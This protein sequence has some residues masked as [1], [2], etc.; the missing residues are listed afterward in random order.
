[1]AVSRASGIDHFAHDALLLAALTSGD[2]LEA[3]DRARA[4]AQVRDCAACAALL[5]DLVAIRAATVELPAP[6]RRRDFRLTEADAARLRPAGWRRVLVAFGSPRARLA[7]PASLGLAT[8]GIAGLLLATVPTALVAERSG[9][10][11]TGAEANGAAVAAAPAATAAPAPTPPPVPAPTPAGA[12]TAAPFGG[13]QVAETPGAAS[14]K[15]A[16]LLPVA[17]A[18]PSVAASAEA[19]PRAA[20]P[21]TGVAVAPDAGASSATVAGSPGD[22]ARAEAGTP[23]AGALAAAQTAIPTSHGESGPPWLAMTSAVLLATGLVLGVL[24][25]AGRRATSR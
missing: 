11:A 22:L 6:R 8:L 18:A 2:A 1:M 19:P 23:T 12:E 14:F 21:A 17:T 13:A 3:A 16:P 4:D 24:R 10:I 7:G 25:L 15:V 20:S 5:A 9:A